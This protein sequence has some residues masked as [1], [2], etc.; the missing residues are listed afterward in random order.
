MQW[1]VSGLGV[2]GL[3]VGIDIILNGW[4]LVMLSLAIKNAPVGQ[5][6]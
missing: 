3:F 6:T 2:I 4:S 1:P 5:S